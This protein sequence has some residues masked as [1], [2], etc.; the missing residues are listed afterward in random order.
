MLEVRISSTATL[1]KKLSEEG[2]SRGWRMDPEQQ[3]RTGVYLRNYV[4]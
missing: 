2:V 1:I 4:M 3:S